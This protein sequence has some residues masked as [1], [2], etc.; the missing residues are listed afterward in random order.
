M[1]SSKRSAACPQCRAI[2]PSILASLA[3]V[4]SALLVAPAR[5]NIVVNEIFYHAPSDL[6]DLQWVELYNTADAPVDLAGW[7]LGKTTGFTFPAD[8]TIPAHGYLVTAKDP[9]L[10]KRN[11][12]GQTA[13]GPWPGRLGHGS[14]QIDL[15]DAAGKVIDRARYKDRAPWPV[16]ADGYSASLERIS[17][18]APGDDAAN[19]QASPMPS[20]APKPAGTPGKV[21]AAFAPA[22]PPIIRSVTAT[23][24]DP[25][26]N[27]VI[28]VEAVLAPGQSVKSVTVLY[29][30]LID[31]V[32]GPERPVFMTPQPTPATSPTKATTKPTGVTYVGLIP[33]QKAGTLVRFRVAAVA[34]TGDL[35]RYVPAI[36]DLRPTF[37]AYVH[38]PWEPAT[39]PYAIVIRPKPAAERPPRDAKAVYFSA[40]ANPVS[41]GGVAD[42]H[43]PRGSST[44]VFVDETT[45][46]ARVFDWINVVPRDGD[47][48]LKIH[49]HKDALLKGQSAVSIIH[50]G[51][52][53]FLLHEHFAYDVYHRAG[54]AAP[55]S[56][57]VRLTVDGQPHG[58]HLM[59][60]Q[61]NREF[62]RRNKVDARGDLY[63]IRWQGNGLVGQHEKRTNI[64][65]G[66]DKLVK[67]VTQLERTKGDAQWQ[68]IKDNFDVDQV[69]TY[70]AVN[71]VLSHWDGYFNNHFSYQ[72]P[73]GRWQMFPW[74]QD[75]T[76]GMHD[77]LG[78]ND[79][80]WDMPL[81]FGS[82][83]DTGQ[84][85]GIW[86]RRGGAFS[87]PLLAN[88]TF[89]PIFLARVRDIVKN[90]YTPEIYNPMLDAIIPR[91][92]P[93]LRL[94]AKL[95][96]QNP[97]EA[98]KQLKIN[99]DC[100]KQ[101]LVKRREF[102]LAQKEIKDLPP[103][104]APAKKP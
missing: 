78:P 59:I 65:T 93:E 86:W 15:T 50:E 16:A 87:L 37:S 24:E 8:T 82:E 102:L 14:G 56:E 45:R 2:R 84:I 28:R 12:P 11:Y 43:P 53:R 68:V 83:L 80:F 75:K 19:W 73:D 66:H 17:P 49:L 52:D 91:L 101:H 46:K 76:W 61:P 33:A 18:A 89:R 35:T 95:T 48:G 54:N 39:I 22:L 60:E 44:L 34:Q 100:L 104:T 97:D 23:P 88:P 9:E 99:V 29:H 63:K 81:V 7:S 42:P 40:D 36:T 55:A 6:D 72:K 3:L 38:E 21:N 32:P 58:Y 64:A 31:G 71:M 4:A 67:L 47:R 10:F 26:P 5:A 1:R 90:V 94:R 27:R 70:F 92:E 13:I 57:F 30:L 20:R 79:I 103:A 77:G 98:A 74:D 96:G 62:L 51:N 41:A 25:T 85:G 69:A